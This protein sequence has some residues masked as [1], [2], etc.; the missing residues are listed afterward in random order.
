LRTGLLLQ[1][2]NIWESSGKS[3]EA[4]LGIWFG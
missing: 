3:L 2:E 1:A 4:K